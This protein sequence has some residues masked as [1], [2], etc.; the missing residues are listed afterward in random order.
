[1]PV[2]LRKA[3]PSRS[4]FN[5]ARDPLIKRQMEAMKKTEAERREEG[6]RGSRMVRLHK[7]IPA[8]KPKSEFA[9]G[10][11]SDTFNREWLREQREAYFADMNRQRLELREQIQEYDM[12]QRQV[13][14]GPER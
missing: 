5:L 14:R 7:P 6:G 1:M 11:L 9:Q 2:S 8:L 4:E 10:V 13:Y 12:P 3:P